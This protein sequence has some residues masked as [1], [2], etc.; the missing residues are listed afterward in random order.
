MDISVAMEHF[1]QGITS[2]ETLSRQRILYFC[3]SV[4]QSN[5]AKTFKFVPFG[6]AHNSREFAPE[7]ETNYD[8]A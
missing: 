6:E 8:L 5:M 1:S 4:V 7:F 3:K 2:Y